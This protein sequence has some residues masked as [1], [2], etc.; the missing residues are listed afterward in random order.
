MSEIPIAKRIYTFLW[1]RFRGP[2][3]ILAHMLA[4]D[5][6]APIPESAKHSVRSPFL[7]GDWRSTQYCHGFDRGSD[8]R[9]GRRLRRP[10]S[11]N[12]LHHARG[13]CPRSA[14]ESARSYRALPRR[15]P[16]QKRGSA[17]GNNLRGSGNACLSSRVFRAQKPCALSN[18]WDSLS[19][20]NAAVTS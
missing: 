19:F 11:R 3:Y 13:Q 6:P 12:W 1:K 5:G 7:T 20:G 17:I 2:K 10:E 8:S 18:T 16:V 15:V 9:R 14:R 4:S